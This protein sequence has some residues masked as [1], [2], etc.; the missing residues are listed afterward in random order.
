MAS[1]TSTLINSANADLTFMNNDM[2]GVTPPAGPGMFILGATYNGTF[3][4]NIS[5]NSTL[6]RS[7]HR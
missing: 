1:T 3:R 2:Q 6:G 5:N 4:Y 7:L